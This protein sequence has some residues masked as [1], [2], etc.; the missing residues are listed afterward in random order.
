MIA[1]PD[2]Q[3]IRN[4]LPVNL[5]PQ[6]T[7]LWCWAASC[8]MVTEYI[9]N[10]TINQC[11]QASDYFNK[12]CCN[13]PTSL[14]CINGGWPQL[15]RYGFSFKRTR[16]QALSWDDLKGQIDREKPFCFSWRW[17]GGGGHMMVVIGYEIQNGNRLVWIHDPWDVNEGSTHPI[18]YDAFVQGSDHSHWDDFYDINLSGEKAS[19]VRLEKTV[20]SL[21]SAVLAVATDSLDAAL[22]AMPTSL[23]LA[24]KGGPGAPPGNLG[25]PYPLAHL[26]LDDLLAYSDGQDL[27][28]VMPPEINQILYP[29]MLG[30]GLSGSILLDQADGNWNPTAFNQFSF[31]KS[32]IAARESLPAAPSAVSNTLT[33][34]S[35]R[36]LGLYFLSAL[37]GNSWFL[38]P[39]ATQEQLGF[40][41]NVPVPADKALNV[42]SQ[43][44][45]QH[46]QQPG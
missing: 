40:T 44:A 7:I 31:T 27:L 16:G 21:R 45:K 29:V 24:G 10:K 35:V 11:N 37:I 30:A 32:L 17:T 46:N 43:L 12:S 18:S 2:G 4:V 20:E 25:D 41:K 42:M 39:L 34:I 8:Q 19:V 36:A 33:G 38:V 5:R 28:T 14:A 26:G 3:N 15:D 23:D 6:Q 9:G 13:S 1:D 22:K